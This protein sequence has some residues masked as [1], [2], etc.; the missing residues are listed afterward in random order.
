MGGSGGAT[1]SPAASMPFKPLKES[2][3]SLVASRGAPATTDNGSASSSGRRR[4]SSVEAA[5]RG[6]G[7]GDGGDD[8]PS[9]G[10]RARASVTSGGRGSVSGSNAPRRSVRSS[11][12]EPGPAAVTARR[13]SQSSGRDGVAASPSMTGAPPPAPPSAGVTVGQRRSTGI[14]AMRPSALS[15]SGAGSENGSVSGA[16]NGN[17][18]GNSNGNA[19]LSVSVPRPTR[20]GAG[21]DGDASVMS[22]NGSARGAV[23]LGSAALVSAPLGTVADAAGAVDEYKQTMAL[24]K[25]VLQNN[26]RILAAKS[27][28]DTSMQE[29]VVSAC[30]VAVARSRPCPCCVSLTALWRARRRFGKC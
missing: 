23:A 14:K 19:Y 20:G 9:Q 12:A 17:G 22:G 13:G 11:S 24:E 28:L 21:A 1:P 2:R 16:S 5:A 4:S 18:N 8:A 3:Q 26:K 6:G 10:R 25:E 30:A 15:I 29:L 7:S 27:R